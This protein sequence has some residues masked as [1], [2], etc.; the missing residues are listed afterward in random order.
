[1]NKKIINTD[2][3]PAAI[4]PYVQAIKADKFLFVSGQIPLDPTTMQKDGNDIKTQTKRVLENIKAIINQANGKMEDIIR[5]TV[6]L[7]D[8]NDFA[9]MNEVYSQY[10]SN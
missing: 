6:Y 2:K 5:C 10:F 7:K 9:A 3:A 8:I 1:M 4:G